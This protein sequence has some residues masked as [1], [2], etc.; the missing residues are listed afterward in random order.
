[1]EKHDQPLDLGVLK[2]K[3]RLFSHGAWNP[4]FMWLENDEK[5]SPSA[6]KSTVDMKSNARWNF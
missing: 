3:I 4:F 1:V 5:F 6:Q 2:Q